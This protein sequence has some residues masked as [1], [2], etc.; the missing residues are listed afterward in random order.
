MSEKP[1]HIDIC[2][3]SYKRPQLL[4]KLLVSLAA[5]KL[6]EGISVGVIVVDNDPNGT[7]REA[8]ENAAAAGM[9]IQYFIQPEKNIALTR[10]MGVAKAIGEYIAF[11]DD[12]EYA[13]PGWLLSL[14]QTMYK[15]QA[16]VV[17]GP[18][19]GVLPANA[20]AWLVEG[21]F[22][23]RE[24]Y[25]TGTASP[26]RG[27]GNV[28]LRT[29]II[30]DRLAPFNPKYGLVGGEDTDFF[31]RLQERDK[32]FVWCD[33][34][35]VMETVMVD[36]QSVQWLVK[37][38]FRGGQVFAE[39]YVAPKATI[40]KIPWFFYRIILLFVALFAGLFA[41]PFRKTWGVKCLQ[42]VASNFGQLS[43]LFQMRYEEYRDR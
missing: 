11:I 38:A 21:R 17:F 33:E 32:K 36:R 9:Q 40:K 1:P 26:I 13:E 28:L 7:A 23:E 34:A 12:D 29:D 27:T 14:Y 42:K 41:W 30:L 16:D 5:Q 25:K 4:A 2:I 18:V 31:K 22:F 6:P 35:V 8:V 39:I 10:N 15:Y 3:A 37:R 20:P 19:V 43:F 24:R